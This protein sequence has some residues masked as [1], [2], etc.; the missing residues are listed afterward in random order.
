MQSDEQT[1]ARPKTYIEA[2]P[3]RGRIS[4]AQPKGL[5]IINLGY[6]ELPYGPT[7]AVAAAIE[8]TGHR[9]N[10]YGGPGCDGLRAALG[11]TYGLDPESLICGNGSEELLDVIGRSFARPGDE[12]LISEFGYIQFQMVA[13][14]AGADLVKAP[15]TDFTTDVDGILSGVSDFTKVIFLAN[16]NNPT[17]TVLPLSELQRLVD[18]LR[19]DVVLVIDLA[20]GEFT[21][22]DYCN[23][24]HAMALGRDNVIVTRTFSK[25]FGL[26]G[27][28]VGWAQVPAWMLPGFYVTRGMGSVNNMA[29]N[30]AIA[31]LEDI[32]L[33]RERVTEIVS[34]RDRV[35]LA[36]KGMGVSATP[37]GSN[38]LMVTVDGQG[39]EVTEA[40][41]EYLFDEGGFVVNRTREA[42]LEHFMRFCLGTPEQN[43]QLLDCVQAFVGQTVV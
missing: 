10:S 12:I 38:F 25:A 29:Q 28:R 4:R 13:H 33:V 41:V 43:D 32:D 22:E 16:P 30:A 26:A 34:E 21:G 27:L 6:N 36:L 24:V 3:V 15:E 23:A 39:P 11:K 2:M 31:A 17:G 35:S 20:Y 8:A 19:A 42:G 1:A 37:S 40:L 14:R 9:V 5:P 18:N 7:P